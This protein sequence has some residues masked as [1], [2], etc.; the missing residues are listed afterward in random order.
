MMEF[1]IQTASPS[2]PM[3]QLTYI[4]FTV[5]FYSEEHFMLYKAV[6]LGQE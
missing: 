4:H 5:H 1:D 6:K 2:I 3:S